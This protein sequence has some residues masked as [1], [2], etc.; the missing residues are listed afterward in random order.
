M[1]VVYSDAHGQVLTAD[2][3]VTDKAAV[4]APE[5]PAGGVITNSHDQTLSASGSRPITPPGGTTG[6]ITAAG[7]SFVRVP[8]IE[9]SA[10]FDQS[11]SHVSWLGARPFN[12]NSVTHTDVWHVDWVGVSP[13]ISGAPSGSITQGPG[14]VRWPTTVRNNWTSSHSWDRVT[15][16]T[17]PFGF[18]YRI[19]RDVIG[20]FQF[21]SSFF[22]V[23]AS[24]SALV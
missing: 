16:T 3:A 9:T 11:T 22:A 24:D 4:I 10:N 17:G 2:P 23:T 14:E 1:V 8:A 15:F 6:N 20:E 21:G 12:A 13:S 18:V 5:S 7:S 19:R